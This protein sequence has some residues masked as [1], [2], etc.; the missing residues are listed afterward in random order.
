MKSRLDKIN[1]AYNKALVY[2]E[3]LMNLWG[4]VL[5]YDAV[6]TLGYIA[7]NGRMTDK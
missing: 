7:S 4:G 1:A 3:D 6:S 2:N 5:F